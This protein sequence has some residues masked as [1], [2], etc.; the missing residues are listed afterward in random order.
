MFT[1]A[2]RAAARP[3][4]F[5]ISVSVFNHLRGFINDRHLTPGQAARES[6]LTHEQHERESIR[7]A[8]L[9]RELVKMPGTDISFVE[10]SFSAQG[11]SCTYP[12]NLLR[13]F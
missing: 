6:E 4:R 1:E 3:R 12:L 7:V 9:T 10:F 2:W 13:P 5:N 8:R 11:V